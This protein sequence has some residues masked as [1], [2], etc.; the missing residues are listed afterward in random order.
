MNIGLVRSTSLLVGSECF[1]GSP[2][3]SLGG[4]N[5]EQN[6]RLKVIK[7]GFFVEQTH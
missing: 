5:K 3:K 2:V 6:N 1:T 4:L 7:S